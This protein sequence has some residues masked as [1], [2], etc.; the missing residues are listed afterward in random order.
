MGHVDRKKPLCA[1]KQNE[2]GGKRRCRSVHFVRCCTCQPTTALKKTLVRTRRE[3]CG[4]T[5]SCLQWL[6]DAKGRLMIQWQSCSNSAPYFTPACLF[7]RDQPRDV[8]EAL[9]CEPPKRGP[10]GVAQIVTDV[11]GLVLSLGSGRESYATR[12]RL[13]TG[14]LLFW[15]RHRVVV[16]FTLLAASG[17]GQME[18]HTSTYR[19]RFRSQ[20]FP[21][22]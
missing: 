10:R 19:E 20:A 16:Y 21:T 3:V 7:L 11:S 5:H 9:S 4:R 18:R 1:R 14:R 22:A 8:Q 17:H 2:S 12:S 15:L 6:N 13:I